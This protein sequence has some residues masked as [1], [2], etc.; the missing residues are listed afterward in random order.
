MSKI[1]LTV[2]ISGSGKST[3]AHEQWKENPQGIVVVN[4]DK[5]RELLFGFSEETVSFYYSRPD[6]NKLEKQVTKYE[7]TLIYEALCE[8]KTVIIDATHLD[9]KYIT[10]FEYWNV[11]IELKCFDIA[12]KEALTRDMGRKRQDGEK[13]ISKQ[14]TKY[15]S[16]INDLPDYSFTPK[17][18]NNDHSKPYCYVF[19]I[20]GTIAHMKDRSAFDWNRVGEDSLDDNIANIFFALNRECEYQHPENI[21][22]C[23][24]RDEVCRE[25]TLEWLRANLGEFN[26]YILMMRPQGDNRP[27][28]I[29]KQEMAEEICKKYYI[30]CWFDDRLQMTRHLRQLGLKVLNVEHNNF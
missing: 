3:W 9:K 7:D 17:V 27:D 16:L 24:G 18:L 14:Y 8:N 26:D 12:L 13:V 21:I 28:W 10:R 22:F 29:V 20:D 1:I 15:L 23:S 4:R 11:P 25:E 6:L 30:S 5:I 2:G 19:D